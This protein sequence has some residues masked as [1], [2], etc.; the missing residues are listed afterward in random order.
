MLDDIL[1]DDKNQY[2]SSDGYTWEKEYEHSW[3]LI[4]EDEKGL[5]AVEVDSKIRK[6]RLQ[7]ES[8]A[9][10]VRRGMNR[11]MFII[12]DLSK[13]M[14]DLDMKPNRH[15]VTLNV[16]EGFIREYF[17]Q[18]PISQLGIIT[19]K[20]SRAERITELSGNPSRHITAM[21]NATA[22]EGEP[23]LQ[24]ALECARASLCHVPKYGSREVVIIFSSLTTCDPG[25]IYSTIADLKRDYIRVSIIGL[26]AELRVC[27]ALADQTTGTY[28][29]AMSE[30]HFKEILFQHTHPPPVTGKTEASLVM[31]GFP[32]QLAGVTPS[33]CA[34]H[35]QMSYG[36]YSC[37]QCNS[38][39][40]EL[41][42]D[43]RICGLTL[44][45]SPHLA[46]SYHHLFPVPI[47][48]EIKHEEVP[49]YQIPFCYS[50]MMPLQP[51]TSVLVLKCPKCSKLF[52]YDCDIFIHESLHN[53]P[54]CEN[55]PPS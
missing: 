47:Y 32:Q 4:Q 8:D 31:M 7:Q 37:P 20:N 41:P 49:N 38:K 53:C 45:S 22:T 39:F 35:R 25:D 12:L 54:G 36:G 15:A 1:E 46:R 40:C 10:P 43:C 27:R 55:G 48:A 9:L 34:C 50:C 24:N 51:E 33:L 16:V 23:S 5:H 30:E 2:Q 11:H 19:T 21:R 17:D 18:N 26:S 14:A 29:V 52:C 44:V 13:S 42:T 3:D 28:N 6:R